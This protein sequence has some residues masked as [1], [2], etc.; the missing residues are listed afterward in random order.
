MRLQN[1][2]CSIICEGNKKRRK[3]NMPPEQGQRDFH[4]LYVK[5]DLCACCEESSSVLESV[6]RSVRECVRESHSCERANISANT[7]EK[8]RI[9]YKILLCN[10]LSP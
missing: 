9:I 4:F 1:L 7:A 2:Y 8:L 3:R 5:S 6:R 10:E